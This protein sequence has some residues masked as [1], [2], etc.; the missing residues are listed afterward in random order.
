M[1]YSLLTIGEQIV[2]ERSFPERLDI[3]GKTQFY[4][5]GGCGNFV[6]FIGEKTACTPKC[7]GEPMTL[8]EPNTTDAAV[9]KHVPAVTVDGNK[10]TVQVGSTLHPMTEEHHIA[11]I[12]LETSFGRQLRYLNP[13]DEPKAVFYMAEGDEAVS[14]Y[15]YCNLHGLWEKDL[16]EPEKAPTKVLVSYFSTDGGTKQV[17]ETV[18]EV[19]GGDLFE[20]APKVPYTDDDLDWTDRSS[21]SNQEMHDD[22]ARPALAKGL[23]DAGKYDVIFV[24]FPIWWGMTPKAVFTFFDGLDLAGKTIIPFCTS[25]GSKASMVDKDFDQNVKGAAKILPANLLNGKPGK[26]EIEKW[27]RGLGL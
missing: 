6:A 14:V 8:L 7:C 19:T 21:R 25:G 23:E 10:I 27:V 20:I 18:A 16:T 12:C 15:A 5:C 1:L 4:R 9:E 3:M 22:S 26:E 11:F 13:G 24:G 17:A 2:E